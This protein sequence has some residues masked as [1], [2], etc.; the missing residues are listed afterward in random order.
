[1]YCDGK[2][3]VCGVVDMKMF[4]VGFVVVL[5]EFV[6]K[7][8]D[9]V[10]L[11]GFLIISDEEGFVYDGIVK[12]CDLLC[13]CGECFDYCVVGELIFVFIFGDMVKNG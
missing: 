5:E 10:G 9:Y 13:V 4:I 7:Y 3:Y 8:L 11:I 2:F 12:V 6:V 1:M